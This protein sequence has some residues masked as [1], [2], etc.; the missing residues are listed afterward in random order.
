MKNKS[1][2]AILKKTNKAVAVIL[3]AIILALVPCSVTDAAAV[4]TVLSSSVDTETVTSGVIHKTIKQFTSEGWLSIHILQVDLKN[5]D[6]ELKALT[7]TSI[8]TKLTNVKTIAASNSAVAAVNA[9]YFYSVG[10]GNANALGPAISDGKIVS[11]SDGFNLESDTM[12]TFT[13][14]SSNQP[15]INYWKTDIT[16][17]SPETGATGSVSNYNRM[18]SYYFKDTIILDRNYGKMSLGMSEQYPDLLEMVVSDGIVREIRV[19]QPSTEIPENGYVVVSRASDTNFVVKNFKVG[20]PVIIDIKSSIDWDNI[21]VAVSGSSVLLK[22]GSIPPEFSFKDANNNVR[23][24]RT[25]IGSTKDAKTLYIVTVDGRQK[26]SIGMTLQEAANYM[27]ELGA[28]NALNFDGGGS[29]T[30]VSRPLGSHSLSLTN[31]PSDGGMRGVT[32]ALGIVSSAPKA[33]L[34]GLVIESEDGNVFVNSSRKLTI[35]GY[36][37]YFN[38]VEINPVDIKWSLSGVKGAV[39]KQG[40]EPIAVFTPKEVGLA[41]LTATIGKIKKT[42][43]IYSLSS[44]VWLELD[45]PSIITPIGT[46]TP[47]TVTGYNLNGYAAILDPADVSFKTVG[48]QA[49]G[50]KKIPKIGAVNSQGIFTPKE[51]GTGYIDVS[52]G[53]IHTYCSLSV[54]YTSNA[55]KDTFEKENNKNYTSYPVGTEGSFTLSKDYVYNNLA[56]G[57]LSYNFIDSQNSRAVYMNYADKGITMDP[58]YGYIG[59]YAY[60]PKTNETASNDANQVKVEVTDGNGKSHLLTLSTNM[61]WTGWKYLQVSVMDIKS[62]ACINRLYVVRTEA[63]AV[64]GDIYFDELL[65]K[66]TW[67]DTVNKSAIP[68]D[69][70]PKDTA[71]TAVKFSAT[72]SSFRFAFFGQSSEPSTDIQKTLIKKM[73]ANINKNLETSAVAGNCAHTFVK[74]LKKKYVAAYKG[75]NSY[76]V[77][78]SLFVQMDMNT[79]SLRTSNP[80]QWIELQKLLNTTKSKNVFLFLAKSPAEMS[81]KLEAKLLKDILTNFELT[82]SR[83]VWVFY[84]GSE[85]KTFMERGVRYVSSCGYNMEGLNSKTI[86]SAMYYQITVNGGTVTYQLKSMN[87]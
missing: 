48:I 85:N 64:H 16:I 51:S 66:K 26:A 47:I 21:D 17:T 68:A 55:Y 61:D 79:G 81:D 7:N 69:T 15:A 35:R 29:T 76:T 80:E 46:D 5:P 84:K 23:N 53:K 19:G 67:Y 4:G 52:V 73:T 43:E 72:S 2:K 10:N 57:K 31:I 36:D 11:I 33:Q 28:Y 83:N 8:S 6:I 58:G 30:M 63:G 34:A 44:P 74:G 78:N 50:S 37:K 13:L 20:S 3:S 54:M 45:S 86:N 82:K 42:I 22:D 60:I 25:L 9:N 14:N 75:F 70:V 59:V 65:L 27:L 87:S 38:P 12:A 56:S 39:K 18:S 41:K 77:K 1:L 49:P 71:N 32:T 62:P 40:T 24:P